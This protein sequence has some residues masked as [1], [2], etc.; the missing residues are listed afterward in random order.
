MLPAFVEFIDAKAIYVRAPTQAIFLCGGK[1]APKMRGA[2]KSLRDAFLRI[3][4]NPALV[5]RRVLL[6][7]DVNVFY[8]ARPAYS[9]LLSFETDFAQICELVLLFSESQGSI[10][11]LG[12][13]SMVPEIA[14][15]LMVVVR[16]AFAEDTSFIRLGP[17]LHLI[18][19]YG[20]AAVFVLDDDDVGLVKGR[21]STVQLPVLRDRL[22]PAINLRMGTIQERT[23]FDA[24]R[25]GH[26]IKLAVGL[27]QEF[28]G[29]TVSELRELLSQLGQVHGDEEIDRW[30][31]CAEAAG[32]VAREQRGFNVYF[33]AKPV[34]DALVL[35]LTEKAPIKNRIRRR[36]VI[37]EH[38]KEVDEP[39]YLG[40]VKYAESST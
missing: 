24:V 4:D 10:A 40:I 23:T 7:E 29:L 39:R 15:R 14:S 9:D 33:F 6:A 36:A 16:S 28:G 11:E 1:V 37:R 2:V 31:L 17:L 38:W 3:P 35:K 5:N 27:I 30:L 13:F 21:P 19:S 18:H 32:W 25:S 12:A 22:H 26:L 8:L 20:P 34:P